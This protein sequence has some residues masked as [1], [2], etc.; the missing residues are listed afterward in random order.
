[1]VFGVK[2]VGHGNFSRIQWFRK[3][4]STRFHPHLH[5]LKSDK[6]DIDSYHYHGYHYHSFKWPITI[7]YHDGQCYDTIVAICRPG[8]VGITSDQLF[9]K[10]RRE[11][12]VLSR[13]RLLYL[14]HQAH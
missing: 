12:E 5:A 11:V 7:V 8:I 6:S 3:A 4:R 1:M 14:P 13:K 9:L 10:T 2:L